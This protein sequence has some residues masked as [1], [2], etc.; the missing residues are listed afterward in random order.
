MRKQFPVQ[1]YLP[2]RLFSALQALAAR[3]MASVSTT[4]R[5]VLARGLALAQAHDDGDTSQTSR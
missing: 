4:G 3:E 5:R 2:E 1:I